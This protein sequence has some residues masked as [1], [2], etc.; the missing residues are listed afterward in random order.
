[1]GGLCSCWDA[2]KH[3]IILQHNEIKAS[4]QMSLQVIGHTFNVQLYKML[5]SSISK[6]ALILI[7]EEFD[8]VNDVGFDS[9]RCGCVLRQTHGLPC[10]CQLAMY[11]MGIIPL[12]EVHVMWTR[13][14]FSG[15]SE[16]DSSC[17]LSIQ[18]EWD[19]ILSRF[20]E[21]D[22]CGK[23][24]IKNKLREI[25]YPDMTTLCVHIVTQR[26]GYGHHITLL[27]CNLLPN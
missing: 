15:L 12:N 4:F 27:G 21:V 16:C 11:V 14:S 23:V 1:M 9:E 24:T 10:A 7:A 8:W 20:D 2:I 25:A 13:L 22:I 18:Q 17:R 5:V 26:Q 3:V 19:V 6:H